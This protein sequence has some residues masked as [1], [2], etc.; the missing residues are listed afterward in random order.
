[1][2]IA[3]T[4]PAITFASILIIKRFFYKYLLILNLKRKPAL[5]ED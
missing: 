4:T 1:M 2:I 3:A 5:K